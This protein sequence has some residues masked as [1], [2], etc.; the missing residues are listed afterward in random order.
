[1]IETY[2]KIV[3]ENVIKVIKNFKKYYPTQTFDNLTNRS[4]FKLVF[5]CV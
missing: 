4:I 3:E 1:M 5:H 2:L